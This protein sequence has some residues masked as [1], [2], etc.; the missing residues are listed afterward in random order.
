MAV[1]HPEVYECT[2]RIIDNT[3]FWK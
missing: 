1:L 2:A 3:V